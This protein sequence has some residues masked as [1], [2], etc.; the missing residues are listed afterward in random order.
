[1][2]QLVI[3]KCFLRDKWCVLIIFYWLLMQEHWWSEHLVP[4]RICVC[5]FIKT[6]L[7]LIQSLLFSQ[8]SVATNPKQMSTS[9]SGSAAGPNSDD[10]AEVLRNN[11]STTIN[12]YIHYI[13]LFHVC[14]F[15]LS[16]VE[17]WRVRI[18]ET[19]AS[20]GSQGECPLQIKLLFR[21]YVDWKNT[22]NIYIYFVCDFS[23][24][25]VMIKY[26]VRGW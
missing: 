2:Q 3:L 11:M 12:Q 21:Y 15:W 18:K 26:D 4:L 1:M 13:S 8:E 9:S 16:S 17:T 14:H 24:E 25:L 6:S 20:S 23:F 19:A 10:Q 22:C 5:V 7:F